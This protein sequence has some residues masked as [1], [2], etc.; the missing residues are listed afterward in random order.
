[1]H[2]RDLTP[3]F[4]SFHFCLCHRVFRARIFLCPLFATV[5][6]LPP[7]NRFPILFHS[8]FLLF[9]R[10]LCFS[11]NR[12]QSC[13]FVLNRGKRNAYLLHLS[14]SLNLVAQNCT[15]YACWTSAYRASG[16]RQGPRIRPYGKMTILGA[17]DKTGGSQIKTPYILKT[18]QV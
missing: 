13:H 7:P 8:R 4:L 18:K 16:N 3:P 5:Q 1:M 15:S 17:F 9:P 11:S 12:F 2:S 10:S 14:T 6:F